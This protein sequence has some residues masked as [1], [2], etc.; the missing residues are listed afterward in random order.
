MEGSGSSAILLVCVTPD[1]AAEP[2]KS[3]RE[4]EVDPL[5]LCLAFCRNSCSDSRS[6]L[7]C[8]LGHIVYSDT[9]PAETTD[10]KPRI[11]VNQCVP[12]I[13]EFGVPYFQ[14]RNS[15]GRSQDF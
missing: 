2:V 5:N 15:M 4:L 6:Y 9:F 13:K 10:V 12:P 8:R 14:L 11:I 3:G 7:F 1:N